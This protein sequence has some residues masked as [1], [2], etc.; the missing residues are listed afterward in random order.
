MTGDLLNFCKK[1]NIDFIFE[2]ERKKLSAI[3]FS[4]DISLREY[5][6]LAISQTTKKD[7]GVIVAPPWFR[8][9][10]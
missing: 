2:D 1:N 8:Q 3:K 9:N 7:F 10:K 6:Q 5:Q 4:C